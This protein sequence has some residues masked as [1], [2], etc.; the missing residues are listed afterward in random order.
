MS[1]LTDN[2]TDRRGHTPNDGNDLIVPSCQWIV[3]T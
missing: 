1:I 2:Y 3:L